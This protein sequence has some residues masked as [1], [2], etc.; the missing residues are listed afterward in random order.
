M[1]DVFATVGVV[2]PTIT[3]RTEYVE[4]RFATGVAFDTANGAPALGND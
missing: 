3:L 2:F 4:A 1:F